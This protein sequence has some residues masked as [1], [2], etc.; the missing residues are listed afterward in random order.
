MFGNIASSLGIGSGLNTSQLVNDLASAVRQPKDATLR[1]KETQNSARISALSAANG[2][3]GTFGTALGDLLSGSAFAGTPRSSDDSV[4]AVSLLPGGRP[5]A[6]AASVRVLSLAASQL[7][8]SGVYASPG[9]VM[10]S[11][12]L[13]ITS[14]SNTLNVDIAGPAAS[15][16]DVAAEINRASS[17][18]GS[19]IRARIVTDISGSRLVMNG[20]EGAANAYTLNADAGA[21]VELQTLASGIVTTQ[22]A[23][24]AAIEMDGL[25]LAFASN[26][27]DGAIA[28]LRMTLKSISPPTGTAPPVSIA[29]DIPAGGLKSLLG[30][31]VKAYNDLRSGLNSATAAGSPNGAAGPLAGDPAV[32]TM[33]SALGRMTTAPLTDTGTVRSLSDIGIKTER[34][35]TLSFDTARFDSAASGNLDALRDM[36]N[37]AV[38]SMEKPGLSG[39]FDAVRKPLQANDGPLNASKRKYEAAQKSYVALREK[40]DRDDENYRGQLNR[41]FTAMERQLTILRATQSYV[42]QQI[43]AWNSDS[44]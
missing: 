18:A 26:V 38:P 14:G 36:I 16:A 28:G 40:L 4:V 11:G 31:F 19:L 8:R 2:A 1:A 7:S 32:R 17:D 6:A 29:A 25:P 22:S 39:L 3:L 24:N 5:T 42:Q 27:I 33:L 13:S 41:S 15:L 10:G 30:D 20:A 44:R 43:S 21:S 34:N 23:S 9:A 37:P 12:S 35:G